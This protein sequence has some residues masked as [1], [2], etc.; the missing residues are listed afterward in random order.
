MSWYQAGTYAFYALAAVSVA[1]VLL[2][3]VLSPWWRTEAG[4][5][6]MAVMGCLAVIGAWGSYVNLRDDPTSA[7]LFYPTRF[8][9][10]SV[11]TLAIGWRIVMLVRAQLAR[12]KKERDEVR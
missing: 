4:R 6:I 12:R 8:F 7:P 3:A 9:L 2:Y 10:F 5:N 11:L 1:F